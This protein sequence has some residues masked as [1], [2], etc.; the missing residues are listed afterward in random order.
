M[1]AMSN[2]ELPTTSSS[3]ALT[4]AKRAATTAFD[5]V[6]QLPK[7]RPITVS[8][9]APAD[10]DLTD[11]TTAAGTP[12]PKSP[13]P[14]IAEGSILQHYEIIRPLGR[15]G[16]G[17]VYLGRD[18]RL[19]RL[20]AVKLLLQHSGAHL[21]RFL[22][23]AR[24]TASLSH[25]NIVVIHD[26]GEE[27][28]MPYMVLE[29]L[30]GKTLRQFIQERQARQASALEE[31]RAR[32]QGSGDESWPSSE[33][34]SWSDSG[35]GTSSARDRGPSGM[36]ATQAIEIMIPV[37]RALQCAHEHGIVHRD[38][39]PAN[40]FL[41]DTGAVKVLD[42][43]I[44]KLL[45]A[46]DVDE[47]AAPGAASPAPAGSLTQT[48]SM[49]GTA[50]YMS[51]EQWGSGAVDQRSDLWAVGILL[52]ELVLGHHPLA[53]LSMSSAALV[54]HIVQ[55]DVPMPSLR[56]LRPETGKLGSIIDR[57]LIKRKE[58]RLGSARELLTELEALIP[59]ARRSTADEDENPYPGL[60]AF[61]ESDAGRF[62]G[63]SRAVTEV[64]A[65]LADQPM[66]AVVGPSGAGKSSFVRAGVIPALQRSGDAWEAFTFRPGH[67]PLTAV[68]ELL[69]AHSW[70]TSSRCA[71]TMAEGAAS[72]G[73]A[74]LGAGLS[75]A[76]LIARLRA[77]PGLL[78]VQLR[79]R[80]RRRLEKIL[81]FVDQFEELYTLAPED[82][83]AVFLAC[84]SGAA[85]DIGSPVRVVVT[86][87]SDFLDR[88]SEDAAAV[89]RLGRG[90]TLLPAMTRDG[91]RE[92]LVKP[93]V[94]VDYRFEPEALVEEMLGTLEHTKGALP[95]LQFT[96][97]KLWDARDREKRVLTRAT[98]QA[99]GGIVGTLAGHADAVLRAMSS[100][101]K[102]LARALLL[103]L[104]TPERTR[105][106]A[107]RG[108][109]RALSAAPAEMDQVVDRLIDA[110]LLT[111]ESSGDADA[112][113][114]IVHESL[115][116]SWPALAQWVSESEGDAVFL[117]RL[118]S[119]AK[120]WQASGQT[121]ELLWRGRVA[122][123]ALA[124]REAFSGELA[125][126][127]E[128]YLKAVLALS[129]RAR[130]QRR[131]WLAGGFA[132]L[133]LVTAGMAYLA[134]QEHRANR[135]AE[136]AA[137]QARV[138]AGR[139]QTE[140]AR[141]RDA[142]RL[143]VARQYQDDPT[144]VLSLLREIESPVPPPGWSGLVKYALDDG[145]SR[146]VF[147]GHTAL[148]VC[149]SW[150]PDGR[151]IASGSHD[152]SIRVWNADGTGKPLV[153]E[154][155]TNTVET[156]G[157]DP[158][159]KRLVSSSDDG[160]VRVWNA[161]GT[162]EP[163]VL[164]GHTELVS[165]ASFRPDG[166]RIVSASADKTVRV[167][168]ADGTGIPLVLRGHSG[169]VSAAAWSPDGRRIAS[170]SFDKTVRVWNA[171]GSGEPTVLKGHTDGVWD[172]TWSADGAH[173][174]STSHDGTM[175]KW[176]ADG[177]GAPVVLLD[178]AGQLGS[179]SVRRE[180]GRLVA[181]ATD[182][183]RI[184]VW[185]ADGAGE[186]VILRGHESFVL[187]AE[188]SPDGKSLATTSM[189]ASGRLRVWDVPPAPAT[190][191]FK[192]HKG[193]VLT[194]AYSPDGKR[195][196]SA[197][198]DGS[199]Q[200][201]SPDGGGRPSVLHD[202]GRVVLVVS[203]SPDG[204]RIAVGTE[205]GNVDVWSA[206][207]KGAPLVLKGRSRAIMG[208]AWSPDSRR[209]ALGSTDT[210]VRVWSADGTG[211]PLVFRGHT[212]EVRSVKWSPDGRRLLSVAMDNTAQVW[213]A[214]GTGV[215]LVFQGKMAAA[216]S[217]DS[218]RVV[219]AVDRELHVWKSDGSGELF[220]LRGHEEPILA[221]AWSPDG[222]FIASA[223][224]DKTARIWKA[225][226]TG[227]PVVLHGHTDKLR[228]VAWS[229]DSRS[230][231]SASWDKTVRIWRNLD[232][233]GRDD[234]RLWS[235]TRFCL[236]AADRQRLLGLTDEMSAA[237]Y[238]ECQRRVEAASRGGVINSVVP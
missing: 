75:R 152:G 153:L 221:V 229:P 207:A 196:V 70:Q 82:E 172:V 22:I 3:D 32:G 42:F 69:I 91:L 122:R 220:V 21:Q 125:P 140:A 29:Y 218:T 194:V 56:Q 215:P 119:A 54:G 98:Y 72:A 7:E 73:D 230:L 5:G 101:Q 146:V 53:S 112:T 233:V 155:H 83:R 183:K 39:K 238:E 4:A 214:D 1:F 20:V 61:Q 169:I 18:T 113:V 103:R 209:I 150:S 14:R 157:W 84:L 117:A 15:G 198:Q 77:E 38:L 160:T 131:G 51:P 27:R 178:H 212:E 85:D 159:G 203:W 189:E 81:L 40:I 24:A 236:T 46:P 205:S 173:L 58:D 138:E 213:N 200:V 99:M 78:G 195:A 30:K 52:A 89:A 87:R 181:V 86:I 228:D 9:D 19:G 184:R 12:R 10:D 148:V 144:T 124:W 154:G 170:S 223:S 17:V 151:R 97:S 107:T 132:L 62:F 174:I 114:E 171:D 199:V 57:C 226:G 13:E 25:E 177:K 31:A 192:G 190:S 224:S 127:E 45:A 137:E 126:A 145:V 129:E 222:R 71:D 110:R 141:A 133:S 109:L 8:P 79:A 65:R 74:A 227:E 143:A 105:A 162:G 158:D 217:P 232:G 216:W 16:M 47:P 135:T 36:S 59:A 68:A 234:P 182:D 28:G 142:S 118:R 11:T 202:Y 95:L 165:S 210:T 204:Q 102:K 139:A 186:P 55:L 41:T 164:K 48:G 63:R 6:P 33:N 231:A 64:V 121:E 161:D 193:A 37:V 187:N 104:V 176:S 88:V 197:S 115:I 134:V 149:A 147:P 235:A 116:A 34:E 168:S 188:W 93:L 163:L 50:H 237:H 108:E 23:E 136:A 44:A 167:W 211:E 80:A 94:A 179:V 106:L 96:A 111:V 90:I 128:A 26:V 120:D 2:K 130:R 185:N 123:E 100:S 76:D 49:M 166:R 201:W 66:L 67:H 206:D 92:A 191:T 60:S 208:V 43:G 175:R 219:T 225:D 35:P 180:D 156:V